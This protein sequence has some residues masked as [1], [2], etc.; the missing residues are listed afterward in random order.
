MNYKEAL[1]IM[2]IDN[3]IL[4]VE[5][6]KKQY[7]KL[8]LL[9]HPD[10]C[11]NTIESTFRFQ[12]IQEAYQ[13]LQKELNEIKESEFVEIPESSLY[14]DIL[15]IFLK[16]IIERNCDE[17]ILN[18]ISEI[19]YNYKNISLR[20]FDNIDKDTCV[21]IYDFLSNHRSVLH[22]S[23]QLLETIREMLLKKY[24]N[25]L[26][27]KLNPNIDD[28]M[29]NNVYKLYVNDILYLVP[30]WYNEVYFDSSCN[31]IIVICEP[32]LEGIR[33]DD[34]NNIYLETI[35]LQ[36][37]I[38]NLILENKNISLSIGKQEIY[39][40]VSELNMKREQIYRIKNKG[41]SRVKN[42]IYDVSEKADIIVKIIISF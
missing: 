17:S 41:I 33:I 4:T 36:K 39:I 16:T 30:L 28:L 31:E 20:L 3:T 11:G 23:Q 21:Y 25:V 24:D 5:I 13:Y 29:E 42:D 40:P 18:I 34:D 9:N 14:I 37:D 38:L 1:E 10:K 32:E 26:L 27:Y 2:E 19:V 15:K 12:K 6:L 8:A 7:R 35:I 22:L